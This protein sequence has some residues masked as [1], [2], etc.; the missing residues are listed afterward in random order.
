MIYQEVGETD[1]MKHRSWGLN[2]RCLK[3][4]QVIRV[5]TTPQAIT[6]T[7]CLYQ[8]SIATTPTSKNNSMKTVSMVPIGYLWRWQA[9]WYDIHAYMRCD[10]QSLHSYFDGEGEN[11]L[12]FFVLLA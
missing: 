8:T 6:F 11:C 9:S 3:Y 7:W 2:P 1:N 12:C 5:T 4:T 10:I